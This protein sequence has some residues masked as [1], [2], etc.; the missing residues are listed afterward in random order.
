MADERE[1][2]VDGQTRQYAAVESNIVRSIASSDVPD[3]IAVCLN[4]RRSARYEA[5]IPCS[6]DGVTGG[7]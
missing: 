7:Q 1:A 2:G 5:G 4:R 3:P 6:T